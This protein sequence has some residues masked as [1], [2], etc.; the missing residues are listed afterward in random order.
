[1]AFLIVGWILSG[2]ACAMIAGGK[3]RKAALWFI[4]GLLLPW[5]SVIIVMVLPAVPV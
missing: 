3:Q 1:M 2:I 5:L 4:F